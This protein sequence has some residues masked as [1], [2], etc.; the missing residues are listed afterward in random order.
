MPSSSRGRGGEK[1]R[2]DDGKE[3]LTERRAHPRA[4]VTQTAVVLARH[5]AGVEFTIESV[6]IGGARLA[7]PMSLA[8]GERVQILF[9]VNGRPI[10]V[11]A[12][13]VRLMERTFDHD[14]V[15]VRFVKID[16]SARELIRIMVEQALEHAEQQLAEDE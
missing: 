15:A 8:Q 14:R 6:S 10:D 7:G 9:E 3:A 12:E 5:N 2:R 4:E 1:T 13:V 11:E 16:P